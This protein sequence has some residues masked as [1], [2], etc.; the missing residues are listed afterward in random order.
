MFDES[1]FEV[2]E[3]AGLEPRMAAIRSQ[4]LPVFQEIGDAAIAKLEPKMETELFLHI[5]QH[6]RRSIYPPEST[7]A[8]ISTK[9]R[10]Y[11]MEPHF[12]IVIWPGYVACFLAIIDQPPKKAGYAEYLLE[13]QGD[14]IKAAT[15]LQKDHTN[16][17]YETVTPENL[18]KI[19][20]R[21]RD[22]KKGELLVGKVFSKEERFWEDPAIE[23]Q[24]ISVFEKLLPLYQVLLK[25]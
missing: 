23:E 13:H 14:V 3:I 12:Q 16:E 11:K 5:A 24:M 2:F 10:G 17:A 4:I 20:I 19:L 1:S 15:V 18:E 9:K 21:L 7:W 6:R 22:V 8:A 25:I